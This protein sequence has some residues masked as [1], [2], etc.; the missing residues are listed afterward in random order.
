LFI[1]N[2]HLLFVTDGNY[3]DLIN[4]WQIPA[5]LYYIALYLLIFAREIAPANIWRFSV[6]LGIRMKV[7]SLPIKGFTVPHTISL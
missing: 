6:G 1:V 5:Y 7:R 2:N 4:N 3:K